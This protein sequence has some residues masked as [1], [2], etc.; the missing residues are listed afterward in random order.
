MG[1]ALVNLLL[2]MNVPHDHGPIL[3]RDTTY[4]TRAFSGAL[5]I[6]CIISIDNRMIR[7]VQF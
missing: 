4:H 7:R 5:E 1:V 6:F 3:V 2:S